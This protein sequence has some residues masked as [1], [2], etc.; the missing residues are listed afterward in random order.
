[1][2]F[3][4]TDKMMKQGTARLKEF[5]QQLWFDNLASAGY[6][7]PVAFLPD[8]HIKSI[9]DNFARIQSTENLVPYIQDLHLLSGRHSDLHNVILELR[10]LFSNLPA[11]QRR[12]R[13]TS[14]KP[15]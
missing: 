13:K 2:Q 12:T 4:L 3:R 7:P 1:M 9:L 5:R 6:L 8:L 15:S 10:E 11:P 14:S